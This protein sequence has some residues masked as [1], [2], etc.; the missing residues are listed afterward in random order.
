[1]PYQY[2]YQAPQ[3]PSGMDDYMARMTKMRDMLSGSLASRQREAERTATEEAEA[4]REAEQEARDAAVDQAAMGSHASAVR[5]AMTGAS[6]GSA[7]PGIGTLVG[8]VGGGIAGGLAGSA[9]EFRTRAD[10]AKAGSKKWWGALGRTALNVFN[11][12]EQTRGTAAAFGV[13]GAGG[14]DPAVAQGVA[15]TLRNRQVRQRGGSPAGDS[16]ND[17]YSR[18]S[19]LQGG[20]GAGG[21]LSMSN[22]TPSQPMAFE[23]GDLQMPTG[24]GLSLETPQLSIP[25]GVRYRNTRGY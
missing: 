3:G 12:I 6:I 1:M 15:T 25:P 9:N 4:M 17:M 10:G 20:A 21:D 2:Q 5:G 7:V 22:A 13:G 11:P 14:A 18:Y 23:G 19:E 24:G 16:M 8:A